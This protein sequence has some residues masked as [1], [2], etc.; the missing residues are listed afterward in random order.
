[1]RDMAK[2]RL[3]SNPG[4][5]R[6]TWAGQQGDQVARKPGQRV[7]AERGRQK[8][9]RLAGTDGRRERSWHARLP[10][11]PLTLL[12]ARALAALHHAAGSAGRLLGQAKIRRACSAPSRTCSSR[13]RPIRGHREV[14]TENGIELKLILRL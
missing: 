9:D 6:G 8:A 10:H 7:R 11:L 12:P 4:G 13:Q 1:M 2:G 3:P 14:V 5:G